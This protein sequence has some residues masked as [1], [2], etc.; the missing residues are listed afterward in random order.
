MRPLAALLSLA[1]LAWTPLPRSLSPEIPLATPTYGGHDE[2]AYMSDVAS[3]G[4]G[5]FAVSTEYFNSSPGMLFDEQGK[6]VFDGSVD[7]R[8]RVIGGTLMAIASSGR[9]YLVVWDDYQSI[10][11]TRFTTEGVRIDREPL[12]IRARVQASTILPPRGAEL[13]VAWDG[14]H[15]I[16]V[17][18]ASTNN[19]VATRVSEDGRVVETNIP[20]T[21]NRIASRNG[22]SMFARGESSAVAAGPDGFYI[23]F[24]R[25]G[26]VAG[27]R[28]DAAGQ[29]VGEE[30]SIAGSNAMEVAVV[31]NGSH[32]LVAFAS[33]WN[34]YIRRLGIDAQPVKIAERA[35][36]PALAS[37]G[38]RAMLTW[39]GPPME[40]GSPQSHGIPPTG[41]P[42][43]KAMIDAGT[44]GEIE[45]AHRNA[46]FS[47]QPSISSAGGNTL[48]A[49]TEHLTDYSSHALRVQALHDGVPLPTQTTTLATFADV[50]DFATSG[51]EALLVLRADGGMKF[52]RIA[53][54][55]RTVSEEVLAGN[56]PFD[57]GRV[58]WT[59][60][61]YLVVWR[62]LAPESRVEYRAVRINAN[63][64]L[65]APPI[66]VGSPGNFDGSTAEVAVAANGD[67]LIVWPFV[68]TY[69]IEG[70]FLGAD[71]TITPMEPVV[72]SERFRDID[73]A[74]DGTSFLLTRMYDARIEWQLIGRDI[75]R[76][77]DGQ[78]PIAA[79]G[80]NQLL[81]EL[82]TFWT[83][84][85]YLVVS[86]RDLK[87]SQRDL[88]GL[89]IAP[90]GSAIDSSAVLLSA[91]PTLAQP[92][93]QW[94]RPAMQ[95]GANKKLEFAYL[96][97]R[98]V[99]SLAPS[100]LFRW[101]AQ[102]K[103]RGAR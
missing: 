4:R 66:I 96:D 71:N 78:A 34:L 38:T 48:V 44:I 42:V 17:S 93:A 29:P 87:P 64:T 7:V 56:M 90:N 9:N 60:R 84:E 100:I 35:H 43:M 85:N 83:G 89:R 10:R 51:S 73:L 3:D 91:F 99:S 15:Y 39:S 98:D 32:W 70:V 68:T 1:F 80:T 69:R 67:A 22:V 62:Q 88:Y 5:F 46:A 94:R 97:T 16:V 79:A 50:V 55:G 33:D 19:F 30:E 37:N 47:D 59:G 21:G 6:H 23:V 8:G 57:T 24:N 52:L 27:Q 36:S 45:P 81:P 12:V 103:R 53:P 72:L 75:G 61:H 20:A 18:E 63:G 41:S 54:D 82:R 86:T 28:Y 14:T 26:A 77:G 2:F 58:V 95:I 11:A 31:W 25:T 13:D 76:N 49:W 65:A 101:L 40:T 74:T 92:M 102:A